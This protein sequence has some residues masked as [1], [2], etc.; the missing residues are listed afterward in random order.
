MA[1]QLAAYGYTITSDAEAADLWLL[2][3]CTVK[4]PAQEHF[5]NMVKLAKEKGKYLV[6]AGCVPQAAPKHKL[7]Q[8]ISIIGVR[9]Q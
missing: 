3:S 8:G 2:N 6:V 4:N 1:G 5:L 7:L 9:C